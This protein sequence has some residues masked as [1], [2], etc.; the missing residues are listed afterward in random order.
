MANVNYS[1]STSTS[2]FSG[3]NPVTITFLPNSIPLSGYQFLSKIVYDL[4][5]GR[6]TK[7]NTF[8]SYSEAASDQYKNID[9]RAPW[10][11]TLPGEASTTVI[12]SISAYIGPDAFAPTIYTLSATNLLPRFTRNPLASA[13]SFAFGE[14][15]L[16]KTR[17]WGVQNEQYF[18]LETK[19][20][21]YLLINLNS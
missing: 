18:L 17:A 7:V 1:F 19:D 12:I 11:Y 13:E 10:V 6:V 15:H 9:C 2:A 5:D 20:P 16:L 21:T 4:P 8:T 3:Y 14:V